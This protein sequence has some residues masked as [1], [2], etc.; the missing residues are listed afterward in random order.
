[1][2]FKLFELNEIAFSIPF[3]MSL[4]AISIILNKFDKQEIAAWWLTMC[5]T[6][7]VC[8]YSLIFSNQAGIQ[9]IFFPLMITPAILLK[10]SYRKLSFLCMF[11]ISLLYLGLEFFKYPRILNLNVTDYQFWIMRLCLLVDALLLIF[12]IFYFN[13]KMF[14]YVDVVLQ[15][16]L[17]INKLTR[18]ESEVAVAVLKDMSL[19]KIVESLFI[20]ESTVKTHMKNIYKKLNIKSRLELI[21]FLK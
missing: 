15:H 3:T 1:M 19:K 14:H 18:R 9:F 4:F 6:A 17:K 10:S 2:L 11:I 12:I 13:V 5:I 8:L 7:A 21:S 16:F 20:E